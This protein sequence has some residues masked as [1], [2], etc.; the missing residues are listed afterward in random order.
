MKKRLD[1]PACDS[2]GGADLWEVKGYMIRRCLDC[3]TLYVRDIP[4]KSVLDRIYADESYYSMDPQSHERIR[5]EHRRRFEIMRGLSKGKSVLDVGCATG[6]FLDEAASQGYATA[7][8]ELS[9][10]NASIAKEKGH[11]IFV[12]SLAEFAQREVKPQFAL[13]TCLDVIEHVES[14]AEFIELLS[15]HLSP[16]GVLVITTPNYSGPV[17]RV[18]GKK[19]VFLTPPEHLNFFTF[20][21]LLTLTKKSDLVPVRRATFGRLTSSEM[22]RVVERYFSIAPVPARPLLRTAISMGFLVLNRFR[23]GLEM[24]IYFSKRDLSGRCLE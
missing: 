6:L 5:S 22:N 4:E 10:K 13:I 15:R 7:G 21:G 1:C 9:P 17:S 18:L 20:R 12:G 2:P 23:A 19:D 24:E 3:K 14:P 8:I 16:D 11:D